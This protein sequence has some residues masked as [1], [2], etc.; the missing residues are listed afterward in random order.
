M[1]STLNLF[2]LVVLEI[3]TTWLKIGDG[4]IYNGENIFKK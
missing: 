2:K 3:K 4:W 1:N